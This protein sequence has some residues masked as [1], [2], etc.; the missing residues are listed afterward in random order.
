MFCR[1]DNACRF[2]CPESESFKVVSGGQRLLK[3][4]SQL[5]MTPY[6]PD[7]QKCLRR[8]R[9]RQALSRKMPPRKNKVP[10]AHSQAKK[11][12]L[13]A[14]A[15]CH[16]REALMTLVAIMK[17]AEDPRLQIAAAKTLLD[18]GLKAPLETE[19]KIYETKEA[20][21]QDDIDAAIALAKKLLDELATRKAT[22]L[23]GAGAVDPASAAPSDHTT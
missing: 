5:Q 12:E 23:D 2:S 19:E 10:H 3:K 18:R 20:P 7:W 1:I 22:S 4:H 14:L 6:S 8:M 21:S 9:R 17:D 11:N 16:S 15:G 13:D